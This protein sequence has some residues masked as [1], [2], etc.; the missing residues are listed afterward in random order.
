MK[1][2]ES[3]ISLAWFKRAPRHR[4]PRTGRGRLDLMLP[5]NWPESLEAIHWRWQHAGKTESGGVHELDA[6][7][8]EGRTDG[9]RDVLG[10]TFAEG[11]PDQTRSE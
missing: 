5:R 7:V 3:S 9:D 10:L 8:L 2:P 11:Q 4:A 1:K 6:V